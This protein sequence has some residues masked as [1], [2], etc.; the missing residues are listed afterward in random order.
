MV[1]GHG[2]AGDHW[3][4]QG[5]SLGTVEGRPVLCSWL[6]IPKTDRCSRCRLSI[7]HQMSSD[8]APWH[9]RQRVAKAGPKYAEPGVDLELS[10]VSSAYDA[11]PLSIE[12][13]VTPPRQ[14]RT[15]VGASIGVD[16]HGTVIPHGKQ[17]GLAQPLRIKAARATLGQFIE[18]TQ[19]LIIQTRHDQEPEVLSAHRQATVG[20]P[21]PT[22]RG[23]GTGRVVSGRRPSATRAQ[24]TGHRA[25]PC[26]RRTRHDSPT[27]N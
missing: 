11:V 3:V 16:M 14:G 20:H 10:P 18:A 13:C 1:V 26:R 17:A 8:R 2:K 7:D 24:P 23:V 12:I 25:S 4:L 15:L 19:Y 9:G 21:A 6:T 5:S 22:F 27:V